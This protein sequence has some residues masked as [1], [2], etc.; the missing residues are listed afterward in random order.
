MP[1]ASKKYLSGTVTRPDDRPADGAEVLLVD[2][3]ARYNEK[4][5]LVGLVRG[6]TYREPK[7]V[8]RGRGRAG[9]DG[10]FRF[11]VDPT[12]SG[13]NARLIL[14][15]YRANPDDDSYS[16]EKLTWQEVNRS[17]LDKIEPLSIKLQPAGSTV[18][19]FLDPVQKTVIPGVRFVPP[20]MDRGRLVIPDL[21][22]D[23]IARTTNK[24]GI[25]TIE[26][27]YWS[28]LWTIRAYS[29]QFGMQQFTHNPDREDSQ[30]LIFQMSPVGSLTG[31]VVDSLG[32]PL[33][34]IKLMVATLANGSPGPYTGVEELDGKFSISTLPEG[35][36]I[37]R[38]TSDDPDVLDDFYPLA[39]V[40]IEGGKSLHLEID[41]SKGSP[42]KG[43]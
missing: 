11:E 6:K 7:L 15:I 28:D 39:G 34:K 30:Q 42:T 23:M 2:G 14:W 38:F 29:N 5:E 26:T 16:R 43:Y 24:N 8:V 31:R 19:D 21:I 3:H 9:A 22:R 32:K 37:I 12:S 4:G 41:R 35:K 20:N 10:R 25:G 13:E 1:V 33:P 40:E 36:L 27:L 18:I 17:A